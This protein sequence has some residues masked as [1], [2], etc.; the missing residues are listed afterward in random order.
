VKINILEVE[1]LDVVLG[2]YYYMNES[3]TKPA[4]LI[5]PN[6]C[7]EVLKVKYKS[8]YEEEIKIFLLKSDF[9]TIIYL[10]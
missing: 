2:F 8:G 7:Y 6:K 3:Q 4:S 5:F 10:M 9:K 1:Q